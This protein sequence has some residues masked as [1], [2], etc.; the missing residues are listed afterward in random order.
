MYRTVS[1]KQ[2]LHSK[3]I[4]PH[5][6][7]R[8]E[9]ASMKAVG[10]HRLARRA[11]VSALEIAVATKWGPRSSSNVYVFVCFTATFVVEDGECD[12]QEK[13]LYR[14]RE[15]VS[16]LPLAPLVDMQAPTSHSAQCGTWRIS[17]PFKVACH[18]GG[19]DFLRS[20]ETRR[21]GWICDHR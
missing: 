21:E 5:S 4:H 3:G 1:S 10:C 13:A 9:L 8:Q 20:S 16:T 19:K 17:N 18:S 12:A 6:T 14:D 2:E 11:L 7:D 15:D